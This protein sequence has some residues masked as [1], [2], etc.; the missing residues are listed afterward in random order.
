MKIQSK[1]PILMHWFK[2]ITAIL[3]III[4]TNCDKQPPEEINEEEVI[5]R[6][7]LVLSD[8]TNQSETIT[9]NLGENSP[10]I[11]LSPN[12]TYQ[13]TV[14]FYDATD[15]TDIDNITTEVIN[16]SDEHFVFYEVATAAMS[17]ASASNDIIDTQGIGINIKTQWTTSSA[18]QGTLRIYLIHEPSSKTGSTRSALGG[19]SDVE[20]DFPIIIQ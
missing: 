14:S 4:T 8:D 9:W 16:E 2:S 17:I 10:T 18:S 20:L 1:E 7:T 6:V 13:A 12:S 19:A 11:N 5:N 3:L 15:P